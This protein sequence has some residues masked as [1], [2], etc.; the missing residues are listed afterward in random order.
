MMNQI[1]AT[2]MASIRHKGFADQAEI[3]PSCNRVNFQSKNAPQKVNTE[4]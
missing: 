3:A 4:R 1:L 2:D